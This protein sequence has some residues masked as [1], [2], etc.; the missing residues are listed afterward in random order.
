M[1]SVKFTFFGGVGKDMNKEEVLVL[2]KQIPKDTGIVNVG[3]ADGVVASSATM[4]ILSTYDKYPIPNLA[5]KGWRLYDDFKTEEFNAKV[6]SW[7]AAGLRGSQAVRF[8][9]DAAKG[10]TPLYFEGVAT[11]KTPVRSIKRFPISHTEIS[12]VLER[13]HHCSN[14]FVVL[15]PSENY[16]FSTGPEDNTVK[17]MY[18]CETKYLY[19][20]KEKKAIV[21]KDGAANKLEYKLND[22]ETPCA[23]ASNSGS[24]TWNIVVEEEEVTFGGSKCG[25]PMVMKLDKGWNPSGQ[26]FLYI[27]ANQDVPTEK[28][29]FGKVE[30][31]S[32]GSGVRDLAYLGKEDEEEEGASKR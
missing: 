19:G 13:T 15:S 8:G 9:Y 10:A 25:P 6:W 28:S 2:T 24:E 26:F 22:L 23:F 32:W 31:S 27:G 16:K 1:K 17:F 21:E 14:H 5:D 7:P 18:N 30:V 3:G 12:V 29:Y 4:E 11:M 20:P